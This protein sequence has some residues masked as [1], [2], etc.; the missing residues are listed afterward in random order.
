[1]NNL[2]PGENVTE[3]MRRL[4]KLMRARIV[5]STHSSIKSVTGT[6]DRRI[7][8]FNLGGTRAQPGEPYYDFA[9]IL[10]KGAEN[11]SK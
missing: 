5:T 4:E 6:R 7:I 10:I 1:M 3:K 8:S 9:N 11:L 2:K